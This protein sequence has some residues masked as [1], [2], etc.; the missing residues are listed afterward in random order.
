MQAAMDL[1]NRK[2]EIENANWKVQPRHHLIP[3][4]GG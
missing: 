3:G 1:P 4:L 2:R